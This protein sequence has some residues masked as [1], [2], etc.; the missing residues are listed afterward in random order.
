MT[1]SETKEALL[2]LLLGLPELQSE[3]EEDIQGN[4]NPN[5]VIRNEERKI[6]RQAITAAITGSEGK[7]EPS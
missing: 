3:W 7:D 2:D 5:G 1:H 6:F 4:P